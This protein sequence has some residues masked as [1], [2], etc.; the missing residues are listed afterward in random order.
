M[1]DR[2]YYEVLGVDRKASADEI[3]KAYRE[4]ARKWHP[5][6][7]PD[8]RA[9]EQFQALVAAYVDDQG[10]LVAAQAGLEFRNRNRS[11][12]V[13]LFSRVRLR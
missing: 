3:K 5:D 12:A 8:P 11:H 7:N 2:D 10:R 4:L 1:A 13:L 6:R 9:T